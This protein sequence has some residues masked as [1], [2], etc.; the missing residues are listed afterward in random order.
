[1]SPVFATN[2]GLSGAKR[3]TSSVAASGIWMLEEQ[4]L[5]K[6][7]G[8]WPPF[9]ISAL[10]PTFW[11]DFS[12]SSTVT[13]SGG[14]VTQV[15]AKE[16]YGFTLTGAGGGSTG[17]TYGTGING[18]NC[19]DF[20]SASH[21]DFLSSS[22]STSK[23]IGEFYIVLDASF[24]STFPSYNG[25]VTGVTGGNESIWLIGSV[26]GAGV[27]GGEFDAAYLNGSTSNS[28]NSVLPTINSPC[29]L[30]VNKVNNNSLTSGLGFRIGQDRGNV[31]R[32]WY[33]LIGEI[34]VFSAPLDTPN[35]QAVQQ[36]LASKWG[37]TLV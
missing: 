14:V 18:L 5:A 13:T 22:N 31:P 24:G 34:M 19:I 30:R 7:A 29:L 1:M 9:S 35:R 15:S 36:T 4:N 27:Y 12:D 2:G 17:P 10:S 33:G 6:R 8:L 3:N 26:N 21:S 16:G 32:A 37:I 23:L 28:Y 25:L 11:Y 20:G